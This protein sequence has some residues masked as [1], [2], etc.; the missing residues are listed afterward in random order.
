MSHHLP[1]SAAA[2][3]TAV[4]LQ[5]CT[6]LYLNLP[7]EEADRD[8][9]ITVQPITAQLVAQKAAAKPAVPQLEGANPSTYLYRVG[10]GDVLDISIPSI[11]AVPFN[12]APSAYPTGREQDRGFIVAPD[13]TIY[14]PYVGPVKVQGSSIREMQDQVVK[15]LSR[16][17]KTPQV[18]VSVTQFRSQKVLVAGQVPKP[19]YLPVTDV[20]LT[21]VGA[22]TLAGSTPLLRGD[23]V[24]RPVGTQQQQNPQA[25]SGDYRRVQITRGSKVEIFDVL[26]LLK[27]GDLRRDPLLQD[28]DVVYVTPVERSYVYVLGEVKQ[29]ALLEIVERRTSLAEVLMASGGVNQ[30]TAKAERV[31]VIRGRLEKPD[32]FQLNANEADALLLADAFMVQPRD[33][34]YVAEANISRWN[35]FLTQIAPSLQTLLQGGIFANTVNN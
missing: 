22:L 25:E 20:P 16:F 2:L 3:L 31:Y 23:L 1:A 6:G 5:A 29:P 33:V 19:G 15:E 9:D 13:G 35:R 8:L 32:V 18:S 24:A 34:I 4:C 10:V 11:A 17:I 27:S 12:T 7:N 28:S 14:L 30:Q 26:A 21:L